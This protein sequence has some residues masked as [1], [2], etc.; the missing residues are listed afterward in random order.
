MGESW[1]TIVGV[2]AVQQ[3]PE[4]FYAWIP[5]GQMVDVLETD[6]R[7][8]RDLI[9][10]AERIGDTELMADLR[11]MGEP[12]YRD[13]PLANSNLFGWHEYLYKP[14]TPSD[15]YLLRGEASGLDPFGLLESEYNFIDKANVLRGLIDSFTLIQGVS[16]PPRG[17]RVLPGRAAEL[18]GRRAIALEWFDELGAP[19]KERITFENAAHS[20]AF[21]QAD[22]VQRLLNKTIVPATY[23]K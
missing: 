2:L 22:E 1:G 10:Y 13:I 3:R 19:A 5:S 14:Y 15:S 21:E 11:V 7:V 23:R 9:E 12:P 6:R 8:Y 17:S 16:S 20:V 4:L 18:D